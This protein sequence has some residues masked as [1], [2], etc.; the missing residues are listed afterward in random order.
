MRRTAALPLTI[1]LITGVTVSA[2]VFY[3]ARLS[4]EAD[5]ATQFRQFAEARF[6]ALEQQIRLSQEVAVSTKGLFDASQV[7]TR[8]E[9]EVFARTLHRRNTSIQAIEWA[10]RVTRN[11]REVL[12]S[13]LRD[14]GYP[15]FGIIEFNDDGVPVR[16]AEREDYYPILYIEPFAVNATAFGLDQLSQDER[17][18]TLEM[19]RDT[20]LLQTSAPVSLAQE[21]GGAPGIVIVQPVYRGPIRT[22]ADRRQN[23]LGFTSVVLR[24]KTLMETALYLSRQEEAPIHTTILDVTAGHEQF[25]HSTDDKVSDFDGTDL[26][27]RGTIRF[28]GRTWSIV[29]YPEP[30]LFYG[31]AGWQPYVLLAGC[32][33]LTM[34]LVAYQYAGLTR[35]DEVRRLVAAR[36]RELEESEIRIRSILESATN[37]IMLLDSLGRVQLANPAAARIF[38]Y[39]DSELQGV[40]FSHL[41][42]G[43]AQG[44]L[45]IQ[46]I[47]EITARD[48]AGIDLYLHLGISPMSIDKETYYIAVVSDITQRKLVEQAVRDQK[49]LLQAITQ[50]MGEGLI[51]TTAEEDQVLTN[52][53]AERMF[54]SISSVREVTEGSNSHGICYPDTGEPLPP[55]ELPLNRALHGESFENLELLVRNDLH[56]RGL[57][58]EVSGRPLRRTVKHAGGAMIVVRDISHRKEAE[59]KLQMYAKQLEAS[60]RELDSFTRAASHDLQEPLRKVQRFGSLILKT[61]AETLDEKTVGYLERMVS[62]A[63]RMSSLIESLLA[64]SRVTTRGRPFS[65]VDLNT[66]LHEVLEDLE[67]AIADRHARIESEPLPVLD[68]DPVQ[69]RQ[70]FQNLVGNAVKYVAHG[71]KPLVKVWAEPAE[72]SGDGTVMTYALHVKDNG[73]GFKE[74]YAE[75]IFGVFTRLHGKDEYVGSGVGL[76]ICRKIVE[77]HRGSISARSAPG[78]GATFTV[79]LPALQPAINA[80][81]PAEESA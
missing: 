33:A 75:R 71:A 8:D 62:A 29:S 35:E 14:S 50:N 55:G 72:V 45:L 58:I 70:L 13:A 31:Q 18:R 34:I 60:N 57:Y 28:G 17:R 22:V 2:F 61:K 43:A 16:A 79:V 81:E 74:E 49:N 23:I 52:S 54:G 24:V 46:G 51:V 42:P 7:V 26:A 56:P 68:A 11:N 27:H 15:K 6:G 67:I 80:E 48:S 78:E 10:P 30:E 66:V 65:R 69:M 36:T 21:I 5:I 73:I 4:L 12:E 20:A 44:T 53:A 40:D 9:F 37:G 25:L 38:G 41:F 47:R 77:R 19:A 32:L 1:I 63:D 76:S 59:Q 39:A 64:L 3:L